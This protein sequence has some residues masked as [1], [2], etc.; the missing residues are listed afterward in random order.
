VQS[1][2]DTKIKPSD[3]WRREIDWAVSTSSVAVLLVSP[4][5]LDSEFI[6]RNELPPL[7]DGVRQRGGRVVWI[8]LSASSFEETEIAKYQAAIDP[9]RPLDT[10]PQSE[11]NAAW[12][13]VCKMI[14]SFVAQ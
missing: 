4:H 6:V 2:D 7:L 5:F 11:R 14:K 13:R 8:P 10:M 3:E 1:W 9:Q 12:V